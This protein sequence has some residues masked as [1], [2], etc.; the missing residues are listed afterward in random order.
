VPKS[1]ASKSKST[2]PGTGGIHQTVPART[3][4]TA[5]PVATNKTA[6]FGNRVSVKISEQKHFNATAHGIGEVSGPAL[7]VTF[8]IDNGST[9][10]IDLSAVTA[11]LQDAAGTP[12]NPMSGSPAKPFSGRLA[13]G[14]SSTGTYVFSL[15]KDHRNPV[16][17]GFSYT[18]E[19]PVVLFV[20]N[21]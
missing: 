11:T 14:K 4:E 15:P 20:G 18:T 9:R 1:S 21:A 3:L 17:I 12:A 7:A 8:V 16:T 5:R 13:P 6:S 10:S 2:P 19:A